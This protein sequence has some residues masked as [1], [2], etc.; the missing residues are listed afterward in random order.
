MWAVAD[1]HVAAQVE[2]AHQAAVQDAL[3]F[4][5]RHALFDPAGRN[6]IRQVDVTGRRRPRSRTATAESVTRI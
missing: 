1:L 2:R 4:I 6:G 3:T 5:E